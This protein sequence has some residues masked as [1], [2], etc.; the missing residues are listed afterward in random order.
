[1]EVP[2][3]EVVTSSLI[4]H[5]RKKFLTKEFMEVIN[6]WRGRG[7]Y[8]TSLGDIYDSEVWREN[9]DF[10]SCPENLLIGLYVDWGGHLSKPYSVGLV[11]IYFFNI[12]RPERIHIKHVFL[13]CVIPGPSQPS[14][15]INVY[16]KALI[17]ELLTLEE[18]VDMRDFWG[19]EIWVRVRLILVFGDQPALRKLAGF[20]AHNSLHPCTKCTVLIKAM[21]RGDKYLR[22]FYLSRARSFEEFKRQSELYLNDPR[23]CAPMKHGC[24][25][26]VI[27]NLPYFNSILSHTIDAMHT[28][29]LGVAEQFISRTLLDVKSELIQEME[30]VMQSFSLP[31]GVG[32]LGASKLSLM[33]SFNNAY[34]W[35][36]WILYHSTFVFQRIE[37]EYPD[38]FRCWLWF[39]RASRIFF[40]WSLTREEIEEAQASLDE[41]VFAYASIF[42][43]L[44]ITINIHNLHHFGDCVK[45][46]G[47]ASVFWTFGPERHL[48]Q[49]LNG[50]FSNRRKEMEI[51]KHHFSFQRGSFSNEDSEDDTAPVVLTP[52]EMQSSFER[53]NLTSRLEGWEEFSFV[54]NTQGMNTELTTD[55]M[56]LLLQYLLS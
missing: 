45:R 37:S 55:H 48:G 15:V 35:R 52:Q 49:S 26:S 19:N 16:L 22:K 46:Y 11:Y 25:H 17:D 1:V 14:F 12:Q 47:P 20:L 31:P 54:P 32:E 9:E 13:A 3:E 53:F 39:V 33:A 2:Q 42:S 6:K 56:S 38:L 7:R 24:R 23:K 4:E 41:F 36:T 27:L 34:Q 18:G 28:F 21:K 5:L 8:Q 50:R 51:A 30:K 44:P 29:C 43:N 40:S 10:L